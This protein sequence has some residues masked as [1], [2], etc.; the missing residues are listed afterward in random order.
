MKKIFNIFPAFFL[1]FVVGCTSNSI[2]PWNLVQNHLVS[3]WSKDVNPE[4]PWPEYPRPQMERDTWLS[5][6]GL[7]DYTILSND[8]EVM[9]EKG[10]ILVP[11][12]IESALSGIGK[13]VY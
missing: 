9:I 10:Q 1:V 13:R 6:N 5:L 2:H 7:W 8:K 12:P 4:N 11:Y 3:K